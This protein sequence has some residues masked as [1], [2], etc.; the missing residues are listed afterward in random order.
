MRS[1]ETCLGS[2]F[3]TRGVGPVAVR[4]NQTA[5]LC[6]FRAFIGLVISPGTA[7]LASLQSGIRLGWIGIFPCFEFAG[8]DWWRSPK[9]CLGSGFSVVKGGSV[10]PVKGLIIGQETSG[11]ALPGVA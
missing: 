5:V 4:D 9:N 2:G 3:S 7:S 1:L 10:D 11:E 6:L 8:I